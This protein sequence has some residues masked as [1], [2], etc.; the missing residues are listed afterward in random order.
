MSIEIVYCLQTRDGGFDSVRRPI[1]KNPM[2]RGPIAMFERIAVAAL[3][4]HTQ[5]D[6]REPPSA[7]GSWLAAIRAIHPTTE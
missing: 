3:E 7:E 1:Y 6:Y 5:P 4:A 2:P